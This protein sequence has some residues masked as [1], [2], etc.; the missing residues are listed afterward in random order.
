MEIGAAAQAKRVN[1]LSECGGRPDASRTTASVMAIVM[2][3]F[4]DMHPSLVITV[5]VT[6]SSS[7]FFY[8]VCGS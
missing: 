6:R 2:M 5:R 4:K 7:I 8:L 1:I 3:H